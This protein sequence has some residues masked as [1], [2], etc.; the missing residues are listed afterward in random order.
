MIK[1]LSCLIPSGKLRRKFR[2]FCYGYRVYKHAGKIGKN[3]ICAGYS[4]CTSVNTAIGDNVRFNGIK[5][6]GTGKVLIGNYFQ[7]GIECL[8]LSQ[9]HDWE[10]ETIP[11]G[12]QFIIKD[13][14]IE[15]FVWIGSRVTILPGA[16]IGEGAII[17]AGAVV[18]GEIPP[19]AI[20]GGNPAR[21][22]KYR[23]IEHFKELKENKMF[24]VDK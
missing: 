3:F 11:F 12:K 6:M 15:D 5:I 18:A 9:N 10:G 21:V 24:Y 16:K 20:A 22:I 23:N 14:V 7:S 8:I 4:S 2:T 19:Y 13:V 17:G 1:L